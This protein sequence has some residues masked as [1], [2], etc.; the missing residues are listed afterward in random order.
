MAYYDGTYKCGHKGRTDVVGPTKNRQ[1]IVD[2]HFENPCPECYKIQKEEEKVKANAAA[3][4]KAKEMELPELEGTEKQV[5]WANTLR[6]Q[7]IEKA[8][9]E[10]ERAEKRFAGNANAKERLDII[11][12]IFQFILANKTKASYYIDTRALDLEALFKAT[13]LEM[14][15]IQVDSAPE[16]KAVIEEEKIVKQS[17]TIYPKDSKTNSIADISITDTSV[18]VE[19]EKNDKFRDIVKSMDF[20]WESGKWRRAINE[21][22]GSAKE[23]AAELGNKLLNLGIPISLENIEVRQK[24]IDGTYEPEC[25]RWIYKRKD[26]ELFAINWTEKNDNLYSVA[27]KLPGSKWDN[28]FVVVNFSHYKDVEEFAEMYGFNFT[29]I[30]KQALKDYKD[31]IDKAEKITPAT[32][33]DITP[34]DGLKEILK[35]GSEVLDDLKD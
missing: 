25:K 6:Q 4:E 23:R 19:F 33:K 11:Y 2:R 18:T 29:T 28:P 31:S 17:T 34:K 27:R 5:A 35:S 16:A 32:V 1:W 24:A 9:I 20:A 13:K 22:T 8:T 15:K 12:N 26:H 10:I 21:T 30:V 3:A 7:M 14:D